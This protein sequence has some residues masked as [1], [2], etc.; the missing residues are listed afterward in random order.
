MTKHLHFLTTILKYSF[1]V[2]M[3]KNSHVK[4]LISS[5]YTKDNP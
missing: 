3:I 1:T 5:L 4:F 2:M